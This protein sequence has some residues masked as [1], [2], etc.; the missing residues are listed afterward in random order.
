MMNIAMT[1]KLAAGAM[2]LLI[3]M[4]LAVF[5]ASRSLDW[6]AR[7]GG[8][9]RHIFAR[10]LHEHEVMVVVGIWAALLLA[11]TFMGPVLMLDLVVHAPSLRYS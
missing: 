6:I 11:A 9:F 2:L 7:G 4:L 1:A 10:W 5:L 3:L 8:T